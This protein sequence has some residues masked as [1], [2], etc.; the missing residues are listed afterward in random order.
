MPVIIEFDGSVRVDP[1]DVRCSSEVYPAAQE[2]IDY[3]VGR[4]TIKPTTNFGC[5]EINFV[6]LDTP[7]FCK[8]K[9]IEVE[10]DALDEIDGIEQSVYVAYAVIVEEVSAA[11]KPVVTAAAKK[12]QKT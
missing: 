5:R 10:A 7:T 8:L 3:L 12:K 2:H 6:E 1:G 4:T 9:H 11:S